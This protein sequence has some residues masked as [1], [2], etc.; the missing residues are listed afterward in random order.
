[1]GE[2]VFIQRGGEK[3]ELRLSGAF[4]PHGRPFQGPV[5][6]DEISV[7]HAEVY[8][9][10]NS[11]PTR[12]LFGT[13]QEPWE[14]H[15]RF[16]DRIGGRGFCTRMVSYIKDF[17]AD[18]HQVSV[19]WGA[20]VM[21]TGMIERFAPSHESEHDVAWTMGILVDEDLKMNFRTSQPEA[22]VEHLVLNL[23]ALIDEAWKDI[24]ERP[25]T[26]KV[27]LLDSLASLIGSINT[28]F[29]SV[30]GIAQSIGDFERGLV[31]ELRR[32]RAGLLQLRTAMIT[33]QNVISNTRSDVALFSNSADDSLMFWNARGTTGV[34]LLNA[35]AQTLEMEDAA[36]R[37]ERGR[38]RGT[39]VARNGDT[40]ESIAAETTGSAERAKEVR[41]INGATGNP[42]PATQY[43]IPR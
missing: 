6:S 14:I 27:G 38:I 4:A 20:V 19:R 1:M 37:A 2:F 10:G 43:L 25:P 22:S 9:A 13:K 34:A 15:G 11:V 8:Y 23:E 36:L 7:R 3:K 16:S 5:V 29:A 17:V 30:A 26:M 40:W 28:L 35:I 42:V 33:A 39:Y 31:S 24:R 32:L 21:V 18:Q 12:H 41:D